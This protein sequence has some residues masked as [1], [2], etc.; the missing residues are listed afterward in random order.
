MGCRGENW[1]LDRW[2][3]PESWCVRV[4]VCLRTI[5]G[6]AHGGIELHS[7]TTIYVNHGIMWKS[8][9]NSN[10]NTNMIWF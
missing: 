9:V 7:K 10:P 8:K 2:S 6:P 4:C 5:A 3:S 1:K